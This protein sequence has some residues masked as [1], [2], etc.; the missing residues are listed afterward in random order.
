MRDRIREELSRN[1]WWYAVF[2][3]IVV[4]TCTLAYFVSQIEE[5]KGTDLIVDEVYFRTSELGGE[6]T[7]LRILVFLTNDGKG[8]IDEVRVRAFA[9]ETDSNLAR[10]EDAITMGNIKGKS[11]SEGELSIT[12]PNNDSY[13][14]ELLVFEEGKLTIRG[15][16]TVDL[17]GVGVASDYENIDGDDDNGALGGASMAE[18]ADKASSFL[19]AVCILILLPGVIIAIIIFAVVQT[20][21]KRTEKEDEQKTWPEATRKRETSLERASRAEPLSISKENSEKDGEYDF[22]D[23]LNRG[24]FE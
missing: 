1:K 24:P 5:E 22:E 20:K 6:D 16:G 18:T 13:R 7:D 8:D 21:R 12:V 4:V 19:G 17:K 9:V 10:D 14:I 23:D 3:L 2:A 15:A 11:T